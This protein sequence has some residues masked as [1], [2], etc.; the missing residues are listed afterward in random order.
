MMNAIEV[1]R[2]NIYFRMS[3]KLDAML[4]HDA[5]MVGRVVTVKKCVA[6]FMLNN[7]I[8]VQSYPAM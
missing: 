3:V 2:L 5:A 1:A 6:V 8:F 7:S 4:P